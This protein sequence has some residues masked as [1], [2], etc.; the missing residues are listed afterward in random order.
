MKLPSSSTT[1]PGGVADG[2]C[3]GNEPGT[4]TLD[5]D[6]VRLAEVGEDTPRVGGAEPLLERVEEHRVLRLLAAVRPEARRD[7][8]SRRDDVVR[9]E[10][11]RRDPLRPVVA[12]DA[13]RVRVDERE[14]LRPDRALRAHRVELVR[15]ERLGLGARHEALARQRERQRIEAGTSSAATRAGPADELEQEPAIGGGHPA[16]A[17]RDVGLGLPVTC[18][19]PNASRT[20]VTPRRGARACARRAAPRAAPA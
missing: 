11:R 15:E 4:L 2:R 1:L 19:T 17:V 14:D 12:V 13:G 9:R 18:A 7:E 5:S 8:R 3:C 20:I 10:R 16:R 6:V